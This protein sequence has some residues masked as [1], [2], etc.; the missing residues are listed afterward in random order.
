ME[1]HMDILIQLLIYN[2]EKLNMNVAALSIQLQNKHGRNRIQFH[3]ID[4]LK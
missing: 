1:K 3:I 2:Y 4:K